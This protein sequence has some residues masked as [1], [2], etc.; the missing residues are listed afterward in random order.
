VIGKLN[1]LEKSTR[2]DLAFSVH[3]CAQYMAWR[4]GEKDR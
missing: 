2:D 1:Y 4:S 3:E